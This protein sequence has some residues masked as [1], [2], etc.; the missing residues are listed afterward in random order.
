MQ[1]F[2]SKAYSDSGSGI[3]PFWQTELPVATNNSILV[4]SIIL[5]HFG[6]PVDY[7][8]LFCEYFKVVE[9]VY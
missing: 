9:P 1:V 8:L 2:I 4:S 3:L 6:R 5:N 7:L